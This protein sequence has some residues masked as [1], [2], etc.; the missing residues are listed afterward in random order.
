MEY[1]KD[2]DYLDFIRSLNMSYKFVSS[3]PSVFKQQISFDYQRPTKYDDDDDD[4][5]KANRYSSL[6]TSLTK[7]KIF[8]ENEIKEEIETYQVDENQL[9]FIFKSVDLKVEIFERDLL[10][11]IADVIVNAANNRLQLGGGVAGAIRSKTGD[12]VQ[13]ECDKYTS[14]FYKRQLSDGSVRIYLIYFYLFLYL[15]HIFNR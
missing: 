9:R 4:D 1:L 10:E 14:N 7:S 15:I 5:D 6:P 8:S 13:D 11:T 12:K 3:K 2:P